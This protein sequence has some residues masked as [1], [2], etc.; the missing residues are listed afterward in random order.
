MNYEL[1]EF[2]LDVQNVRKFL[3]SNILLYCAVLLLVLKIAL[4][5]VS[6]NIP[7]NIFFADITKITLENLANRWV[8]AY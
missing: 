7:F 5:G 1:G 2:R 3:L 4:I 8:W 6:L